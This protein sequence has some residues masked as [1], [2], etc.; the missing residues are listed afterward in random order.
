MSTSIFFRLVINWRK[1]DLTWQCIRDDIN[2]HMSLAIYDCMLALWPIIQDAIV[3]KGKPSKKSICAPFVLFFT[4]AFAGDFGE[5]IRVIQQ[6]RDV[7][8]GTNVQVAKLLNAIIV[9]FKHFGAAMEKK[10]GDKLKKMKQKFEVFRKA[11]KLFEE[12]KMRLHFKETTKVRRDT[13]LQILT[14]LKEPAMRY[15][16]RQPSAIVPV[17]PSED[18]ITLFSDLSIENGSDDVMFVSEKG[19]QL[20]GIKELKEKSGGLLRHM[21]S[22]FT[23]KADITEELVKYILQSTS[24][25]RTPVNQ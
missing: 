17:A 15:A 14:A 3:G 18:G 10:I 21:D 16:N 12:E 22:I 19:T 8:C 7:F 20:G 25:N 5:R 6:L 11:G 23:K 13:T 1:N 2:D 24:E 9:Y 4:S